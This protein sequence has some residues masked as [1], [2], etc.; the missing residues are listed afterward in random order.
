MSLYSIEKVGEMYAVFKGDRQVSPATRDASK[1]VEW[2]RSIEALDARK[3]SQ[4]TRRSCL[5]CR[6]PFMSDGPHNRLC[7]SCRS[8]GRGLD[9]Q[10]LGI[11]HGGGGSKVQAKRG[12]H[13]A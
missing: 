10:M 7:K 5:G 1:T 12:R 11:G 6:G 9:N 2:L 4:V 13:G 8:S 3:A